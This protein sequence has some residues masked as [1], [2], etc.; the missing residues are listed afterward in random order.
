VTRTGLVNWT[1][2][3]EI[4]RTYFRTDLLTKE[5]KISLLGKFPGR[6]AYRVSFGGRTR[7]MKLK[8]KTE[9]NL[10]TW[11][12]SKPGYQKL[13]LQGIGMLK[14][15]TTYGELVAIKVTGIGKIKYN[16]FSSNSMDY[17]WGRR[18]PSLSLWHKSAAK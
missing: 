4:I 8:G 2:K 15:G 3:D 9:L 12:I 16:P 5:V 7:I 1:N 10:R 14:I 17:H 6:V 13:V 18:G 11:K